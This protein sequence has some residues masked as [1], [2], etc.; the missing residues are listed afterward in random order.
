MEAFV[1]EWKNVIDCVEMFINVVVIRYGKNCNVV[2]FMVIV[3]GIVNQGKDRNWV[4]MSSD[5]GVMSSFFLI[6]VTEG[7]YIESFA[8]VDILAEG[9]RNIV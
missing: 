5:C 7:R 1:I 4:E 9:Y 6:C 3:V 2:S 8:Y